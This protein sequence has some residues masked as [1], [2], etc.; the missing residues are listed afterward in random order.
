MKR[1][2]KRLLPYVPMLRELM[3]ELNEKTQFISASPVSPA[4]A[5]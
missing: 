5:A 4:G 2:L 1:G 3:S